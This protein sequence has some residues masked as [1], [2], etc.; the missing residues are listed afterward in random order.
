MTSRP[1]S[2]TAAVDPDL[3]AEIRRQVWTGHNIPLTPTDSTLGP[4][5]P[6]ISDD[7]RTITIK[8]LIRRLGKEHVRV[9]DLGSLEGG[10][11]FEMAREG[12]DTLGVEGRLSNFDKSEL[13]RR[14]FGMDN[15]RFEH[16]DVKS[17]D[18]ARDGTFDAILCCG[19]LYHLDNPFA[20]LGTLAALLAEDG[21]LFLDTHVAPDDEA[22]R[23][24]T[25]AAQ[26]SGPAALAH[27]GH[28]YD[29]RW[30][31]EP[32]EGDVLDRQWSAVSNERSFWPS[33]RSLIRGVYHAGF[34]AIGEL[35]GMFEI[36]REFALRDKFSRLYLECRKAW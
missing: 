34:Q 35:F 15:L 22:A 10:L 36:D 7:A 25:H 27:G 14:Y 26:L 3:L 30:F 28:D 17:L 23:Y 29:G 6:L 4:D 12:W 24:G 16:R 19:L 18:P 5:I 13:I 31:S 11:S 8:A 20:F 21:L 9:L 32:R 1:S 2:T 33:R